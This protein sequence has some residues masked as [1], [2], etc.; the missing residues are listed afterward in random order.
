MEN[1]QIIPIF[2]TIDNGYAPYASCA[3]QSIITNSS[4]DYNYRIIILHQELTEENKEKL[5]NIVKE[6]NNFEI[7]FR[8]MK[9][10]FKDITD[11]EENRLRCDYFTLTIYFRLFIPDMFK[12][13]DKAIYIDSDIIV[14]GD[15]SKLYNLDLG[16]NLIGASTDHSV[17]NIPEFIKY[18]EKAIGVNRKEYINSGVLLMNLK[19]MREKN[20]ANKFLE[21]LN[22]YHFYCIAPDQDYLNAMCNGQILYLGEEWDAMPNDDK[23]PLEKPKLIHFNLFQ[24]PWCYDNIQYEEYFWEYAKKSNYYDQ[25]I[26]FK[27]NYSDEQK[28]SDKNCLALLIHKANDV[29]D[30]ENTF[31]KRFESGEKIRV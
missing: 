3:I 20:F 22:K 10:S 17:Q 2:F 21:L 11:R 1:K 19:K 27:K 30:T 26:E 13:Y 5:S 9:D 15:I 23:L 4:K 18:M 8:E 25:I 31:R 28:K 16:D 14:L 24:K 6:N 12:E 29:P 7:I